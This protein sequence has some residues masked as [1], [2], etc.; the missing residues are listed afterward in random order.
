MFYNISFILEAG[1]LFEAASLADSIIE[2]M[3]NP[4]IEEECEYE[5]DPIDDHHYRMTTTLIA[6]SEDEILD[7][8]RSVEK[9]FPGVKFDPEHDGYVVAP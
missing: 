4:E 2:H 9:R 3:A 1:D 6:D 5:L 8:G 7:V